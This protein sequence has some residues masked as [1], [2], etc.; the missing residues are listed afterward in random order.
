MLPF[1]V[2]FV[3]PAVV[4]RVFDGHQ[5]IDPRERVATDRPGE[6]ADDQRDDHGGARAAKHAYMLAE[7]AVEASAASCDRRAIDPPSTLVVR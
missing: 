5:V 3:T 1:Q 6:R 2:A 4:G 7:A